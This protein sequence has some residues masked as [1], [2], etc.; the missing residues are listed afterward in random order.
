MYSDEMDVYNLEV[1][2]DDD[3]TENNSMPVNPTYTSIPCKISFK[4]KPD[5]SN[6]MATANNPINQQVNIFCSPSYKIKKGAKIV[7]RKMSEAGEVMETYSGNTINKSKMFEGHQ[8][9]LFT[10][11]GDA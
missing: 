6:V 1:V 11:L 8:E 9:I 5:Q 7:T 4:P 10:I 3:G 2:K